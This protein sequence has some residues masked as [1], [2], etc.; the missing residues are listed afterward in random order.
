[1][2]EDA[3]ITT[4]SA[5]TSAALDTGTGTSETPLIES[6]DDLMAMVPDDF[7]AKVR[8]DDDTVDTE[9][10]ADGED[11][12]STDE[13]AEAGDEEPA[14]EE[15]P[16]DAAAK[17]EAAEQAKPD[18]LP[19][20]VI[21]GK[22][23]DGKPGLFV[24]EPRWKTIYGNH[25]TVQKASEI[26]GEPVTP[27][28]LQERQEAYI[29]HTNLYNALL[30]GDRA[31]QGEFLTT[32]LGEMRAAKDAGEIATDA[33]I[34]FAN[35]FYDT[36]KAED[37]DGYT[38]VR[39]RS[40]QEL[41]QEMADKALASGNGAI[42]LALQ[43][44]GCALLGLDP[45]KMSMSEIV[46]THKRFGLAFNEQ[47]QFQ[48]L[49]EERKKQPPPSQSSETEQLRQEVQTLRDQ[50]SGKSATSEAAQYQSWFDSTVDTVRQ[51]LLEEAVKPAMA[52]YAERW[53]DYPE[54]F[55][56]IVLKPLHSKVQEELMKDTQLQAR[57]QQ[58]IAQAKRSP[59]AQIRSER[60]ATIKQ[61]A[62]HKALSA[63]QKEKGP[64]LKLAANSLVQQ[65]NQTH[66]RRRAGQ[67]RTAPAGTNG[68]VPHSIVPKSI[69]DFK[70]GIFD[71]DTV[72]QQIRAVVG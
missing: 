69:P 68:S 13:D 37:L 1:M 29:K 47:A 60:A 12:D 28:V 63:V 71:P 33:T 64:Y 17:K 50:I 16:E 48:R 52:A 3:T 9:D 51:S 11:D 36:M 15:Q 30:S 8:G 2:P 49:A 42:N 72:R 35:A 65:A 54:Q 40:T 38:A 53:K 27:E 39:L 70:D 67:S 21:R 45:E 59:S 18:E 7:F 25:Q 32:L 58:L 19:E 44:I 56:Q 43:H 46:E 57:V 5:D 4:E 23:K 66:D 34:P 14:T 55:E 24:E 10:D 22:N 62:I 6:G 31:E 41:F 61:L 20:G 26:F